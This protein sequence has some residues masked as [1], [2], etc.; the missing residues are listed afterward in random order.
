MDWDLVVIFGF[1]LLIIAMVLPFA[2]VV[3]QRVQQ[4]EQKKLELQAR[5]EEAKAAQAVQPTE[6][7]AALEDRLR[8]LERIVTDPSNDLSRQIEDLRTLDARQE[9]AQ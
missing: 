5:I 3:N 1:I 9:T 6:T 4:H 2:Y 7:Q 8:V